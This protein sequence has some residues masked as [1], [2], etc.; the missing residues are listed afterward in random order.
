MDNHP[1]GG[2]DLPGRKPCDGKNNSHSCSAVGEAAAHDE[3][4]VEFSRLQCSGKGGACNCSR[5]YRE[6]S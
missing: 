3:E 5:M 4:K 2:G 1:P 6:K